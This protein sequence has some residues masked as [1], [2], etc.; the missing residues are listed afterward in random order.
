MKKTFIFGLIAA[1]LGFTACSSEDDLNVND[2]NQK[3]GMVLRATVEQPAESRA[4]IDNDWTFAF[5]KNDNVYV[6][7]KEMSQDKHWMFT[8]GTGDFTCISAIETTSPVTWYAYFPQIIMY[9]NQQSG[10][11]EDVANFYA[12]SGT[13]TST[14]TGKDGL[15]IT[16]EPQVA[17]LVIDN[18]IG[19]IDINVKT[20]QNSWVSSLKAKTGEK[21]F[22]LVTYEGKVSLLTTDT[23]GT[24]YIAVPAGVLLAVKDGDRVIKSTGE[25]GLTAGKYYN[26]TLIGRGTSKRVDVH[27]RSLDVNWIQLWEG[28]PKW[29]EYNV[30]A[31]SNIPWDYGGYY[32]WGGRVSVKNDPDADTPPCYE[33]T[34]TIL[35]GSNW[36]MPTYDDFKGLY[37]NCTCTWS[38]QNGVNGLLCTGKGVYSTNSIFLPAAGTCYEGYV[39]GQSEYGFYWSSTPYDGEK[40]Y[41]LSFDSNYTFPEAVMCNSAFSVRAVL[42]EE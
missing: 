3:K 7:N 11:K 17:I 15:S 28:G 39:G 34:A 29:A 30:E 1:A 10:K 41:C 22:E 13:T 14:T 33:D 12:L 16:M 38:T 25:K 31:Q 40:A 6:R 20:G 21:G 23:P 5:S 42:V 36:R 32:K 24:Y 19:S 9:F 18:Q 8:K 27:E 35:W 37:S 2:N 4:T 26:L